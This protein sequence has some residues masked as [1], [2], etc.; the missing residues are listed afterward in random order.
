MGAFHVWHS[1]FIGVTVN[2]SIVCYLWVKHLSVTFES[3]SYHE[4]VNYSKS[5]QKYSKSTPK[6][7]K[8]YSKST[9]KVLQKYSRSAPKVLQKYSKSTPKVPQKY[10]MEYSKRAPKY[11]KSASKV[12]H[13]SWI[14]FTG[15][16]LAVLK[17]AKQLLTDKFYLLLCFDVKFNKVKRPM[18]MSFYLMYFLQD[19]FWKF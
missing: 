11:S 15:T 8:K 18:D 6:L 1:K 4:D 13:C 7:P 5:A 14:P 12:L 19:I 16:S 10:S 9:P 3:R 17:G 2:S